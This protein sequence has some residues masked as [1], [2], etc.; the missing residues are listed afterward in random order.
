M[1][2][3]KKLDS[4]YWELEEIKEAE[5]KYL[6]RMAFN[7]KAHN[8]S[9]ETVNAIREEAMI[10]KTMHVEHLMNPFTNFKYAFK[11]EH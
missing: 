1:L 11:V 3:S 4:I 9:M 10:L 2:N 7:L 5:A 6:F 8:G